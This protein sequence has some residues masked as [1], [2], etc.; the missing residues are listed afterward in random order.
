METD[1]L[2]DLE[3]SGTT[4]SL[5]TEKAFVKISLFLFYCHSEMYF[6]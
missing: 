4:N 2:P 6:I 3:P 5:G 1:D